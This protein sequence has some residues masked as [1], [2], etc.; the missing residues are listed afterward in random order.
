MKDESRVR[1]FL[2][3]SLPLLS[4]PFEVRR[5]G[6]LNVP[7]FQGEFWTSK[8]RQGHSIHEVS[9]RACY[10]PQL[11]A[12]F[13]RRFCRPDDAV[14]DPF[15]GRGTT[16][17]EAQLHGCRAIGNDANPLSKILVEPR[18]SPP[19]L[20][21]IQGRLSRLELC[22]SG[23]K[24]DG[25]LVFFHPDTLDELYAWRSYFE[26][27]KAAHAF[28]RIDAWLQMVACNRLTGHSPGFFSVHTLP[29]NQAASIEAQRRINERKRQRPDYRDTK[30]LILRKSKQLLR[31][32]F[33]RNFFR[34]DHSVSCESA[35]RTPGIPSKCAKLVVT[36]PPFLDNV[37]YLHD[38]WLR[39]WFCGIQVSGT[40]LWQLSSLADWLS[41]MTS[42]FRELR[43]ILRDDGVIAFEVGEVRKGKIALENEVVGAALSA[44]LSAECI[45]INSQR[46]TKTSN[47]WGVANNS[48]GTNSNRIVIL[49]RK[50]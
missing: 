30:A 14:Y 47:C 28:D 45:I 17:I 5:F 36:S 12:S 40:S 15:M 33:P 24:D 29:P 2:S 11:P 13:I 42:T 50:G 16:L 20:P 7:V 32:S 49:K 26:Q 6:D 43:R 1:A 46:F 4:N 35:D 8:Q 31:D 37:D 38:N 39:M 44:G 22:Y 9:Y 25:L 10:K 18:L 41:K 21:E 27:R 48:G 3:F 19:T 23:P 34:N